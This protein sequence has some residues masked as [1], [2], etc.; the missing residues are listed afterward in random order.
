MTEK[1][2]EDLAKAKTLFAFLQGDVPDGYHIATDKVPHLTEDQ[3]WIVIWYL[4]NLFWQVPDTVERCGV[5]GALFH[6][7]CEGGYTDN[8]PP[9]HFC[10]GCD[11][12]RPEEQD[13]D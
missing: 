2:T 9:Y 8:G 13:D 4:G 12:L 5:C 6:S 1:N 7:E 11:H 3:A 10:D